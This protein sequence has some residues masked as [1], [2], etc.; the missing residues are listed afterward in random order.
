[1]L[2]LL[3]FLALFFARLF[4]TAGLLAV[5][6]AALPL[7]ALIAGSY[8]AAACVAS[9]RTAQ[10]RGWDLLPWLPLTFGTL[11]V[12]YGVGSIVGLAAFW[13]RWRESRRDATHTQ[14]TALVGGSHARRS[15]LPPRHS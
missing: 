2:L 7:F 3:F 12:A 10:R 1:M 4:G 6:R 9:W 5:R 8:L 15:I 14:S 13:S 11:H